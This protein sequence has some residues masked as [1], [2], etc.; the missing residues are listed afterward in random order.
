MRPI[1]TVKGGVTYGYAINDQGV[2]VGQIYI[3]GLP[4]VTPG[5]PNYHAFIWLGGKIQ[6]LNVGDYG[7]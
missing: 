4:Q 7:Q 5:Q 3:P 6:D 2:V 1:G